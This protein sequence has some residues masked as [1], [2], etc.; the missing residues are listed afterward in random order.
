M[1]PQLSNKLDELPMNLRIR[2]IKHVKPSINTE[3]LI[4]IFQH[5][6]SAKYFHPEVYPS[7]HISHLEFVHIPT[8]AARSATVSNLEDMRYNKT[9]SR[10]TDAVL[11]FC[12]EQVEV[13]YALT[14]SLGL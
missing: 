5:T 1:V 13:F 6:L 4:K 8:S 12:Q 7:D 11:T 9:R 2:K 14:W 3:T 10:T